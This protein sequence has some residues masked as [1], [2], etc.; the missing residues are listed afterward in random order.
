SM[1]TTRICAPGARPMAATRATRTSVRFMPSFYQSRQSNRAG[2]GPPGS[3]GQ[4]VSHAAGLEHF[5]IVG[6]VDRH[7]L[8]VTEPL[9][10]GP[11]R[12]ARPPAPPPPPRPPATEL[13]VGQ[14]PD[15]RTRHALEVVRRVE[16]AVFLVRD[17]FRQPA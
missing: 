13:F 10:H 2:V 14:S 17:D 16:E 11:P 3:G 12:R 7:D 1:G 8:D 6:F 5:P 15:G 4:V 9:V